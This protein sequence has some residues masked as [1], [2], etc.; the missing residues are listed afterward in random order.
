[1]PLFTLRLV[2]SGRWTVGIGELVAV[3]DQRASFGSIVVLILVA[4]VDPGPFRGATMNK[5]LAGLG[6]PVPVAAFAS[7]V[8]RGAL[9][10]L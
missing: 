1:M 2:L 4:I 9:F 7:I 6:D 3:Q 5:L 10:V 8:A